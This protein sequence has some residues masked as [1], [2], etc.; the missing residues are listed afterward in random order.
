MDL[1]NKEITFTV[2]GATINEELWKKL[3]PSEFPE[4]F[5]IEYTTIVQARKH[6]KKRIN[7]KWLKKYGYKQ[8]MV[9]SKGWK[10]RT[11]ADDGTWEFVKDE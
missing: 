1:S 11:Y 5:D 8:V 10:I 7:K 9:R 6:R 2:E 3:M 4:M